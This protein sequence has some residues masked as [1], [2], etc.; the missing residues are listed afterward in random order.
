LCS[1]S[2][3][4]M[5]SPEAL[6]RA[7][8]RQKSNIFIKTHGKKEDFKK[9][10]DAIK[11]Q[12]LKR[13]AERGMLDRQRRQG[14]VEEVITNF[15]SNAMVEKAGVTDAELL[16][17]LVSRFFY[18]EIEKCLGVGQRADI[19]NTSVDVTKIIGS[20]LVGTG[21]KIAPEF[22]PATKRMIEFEND[23]ERV[24]P[25]PDG[26]HFV[27]LIKDRTTYNDKMAYLYSAADLSQNVK[28]CHAGDVVWCRDSQSFRMKEQKYI[29]VGT[30]YEHY[31]GYVNSNR[32]CTY[33]FKGRP[34]FIGEGDLY[35]NPG[36]RF[37]PR[38]PMINQDSRVSYRGNIME[39]TMA[40]QET[41]RQLSAFTVEQLE[42]ISDLYH[43][44]NAAR[45]SRP[46]TIYPGSKP[47]EILKQIRGKNSL[48]AGAL[49]SNYGLYDSSS[50]VIL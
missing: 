50:C 23:I 13:F 1:S 4:K 31:E 5:Q 40:P 2:L 35:D 14:I 22:L 48:V 16:R 34:Q 15:K 45:E 17:D 46:I 10:R 7:A 49:E 19:K 43:L 28:F 20:Y 41:H 9:L 6:K 47:M 12:I 30:L 44:F 38:T 26:A 11:G 27:V 21:K 25:S 42:F 39:V 29:Q 18:H 32:V 24:Y 36:G 3:Q 8:V 33:D 37:Y